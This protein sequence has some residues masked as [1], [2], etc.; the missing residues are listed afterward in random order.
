MRTAYRVYRF[1]LANANANAGG[2]SGRPNYEHFIIGS[3]RALILC[4]LRSPLGCPMQTTRAANVDGNVDVTSTSVIAEEHSN[5]SAVRALR[6]PI[7]CCLFSKTLFDCAGSWGHSCTHTHECVCVLCMR[8]SFPTPTRPGIGA[9]LGC[10]F[11]ASHT[12]ARN[13]FRSVGSVIIISSAFARS[14]VRVLI[15]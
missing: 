8:M 14:S 9:R 7:R 10:A 4:S 3:R 13:A 2:Q 1:G 12:G 15:T 5:Y 11:H 6:P